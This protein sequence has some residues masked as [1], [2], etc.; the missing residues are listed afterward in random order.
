M[1]LTLDNS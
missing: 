1:R